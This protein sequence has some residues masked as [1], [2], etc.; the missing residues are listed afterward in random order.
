MILNPN[1]GLNLNESFTIEYFVTKSLNN[2]ENWISRHE[3]VSF[4]KTK[5]AFTRTFCSAHVSLEI[6]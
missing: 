4:A 2:I 1:C 3:K 5:W 6:C